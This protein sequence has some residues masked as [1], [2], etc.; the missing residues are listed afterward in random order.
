LFFPLLLLLS[1]GPCDF[2]EQQVNGKDDLVIHA[3]QIL[4]KLSSSLQQP[5]IKYG[6]DVGLISTV[7]IFKKIIS[8]DCILITSFVCLSSDLLNY[9]SRGPPRLITI[10]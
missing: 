9:S 1:A 10:P 5:Q 4:A 8:D 6:F 2:I 7:S 3:T